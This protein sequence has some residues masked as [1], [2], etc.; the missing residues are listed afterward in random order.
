[1]YRIS[2]A[3]GNISPTP[4]RGRLACLLS[5][6]VSLIVALLG[7][8]TPVLFVIFFAAIIF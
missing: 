4:S 8:H 7:F 1:M 2:S 5:P 3:F 6:A